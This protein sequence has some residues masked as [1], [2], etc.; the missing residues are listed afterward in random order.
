MNQILSL[1]AGGALLA[2]PAVLAKNAQTHH[3][4]M[5]GAEVTVTKANCIKGGGTWAKGAPTMGTEAS[6]KAPPAPAGA[7]AQANPKTPVDPQRLPE[8]NKAI[9]VNTPPTPNGNNQVF[10]PPSDRT[11]G[12]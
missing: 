5:N 1:I 6:P 9:P 10:P 11:P 3:C 8:N 7:P 12:N 4:V 2:A